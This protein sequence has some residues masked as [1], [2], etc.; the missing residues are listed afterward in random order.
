MHM[1]KR[2]CFGGSGVLDVDAENIDVKV[3]GPQLVSLECQVE[4]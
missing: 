2:A 3:K 4:C 1:S